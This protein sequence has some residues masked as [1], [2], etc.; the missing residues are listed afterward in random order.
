MKILFLLLF[1]LFT[2][3][4]SGSLV[5]LEYHHVSE[6]TPAVTSISP[7]NFAAHMQYLKDQNFVVLPLDKA[8]R[9]FKSAEKLPDWALAITFDDAYVD[10]YRNAYPLL[11]QLDFPFTIFIATDLVGTNNR[12]YL[13]WD[14]L[15][16]MSAHG[17]LITNH[18]R[19][20]LHMLRFLPSESYEQW[21]SRI[22]NEI[23][24]AQ[25]II[26]SRLGQVAKLFAFPYGE[27]NQDLLSL[28]ADL[29]Y[30]AFGQQSGAI[31]KHSNFLALPRFPLAGAYTGMD[32]FRTKV[33][34]LPLPIHL[35]ETES[36]L[37]A[38]NLRPRLD[39]E[40]MEG[41]WRTA[42]LACFGPGGKMTVEKISTTRFRTAPQEDVPIGRSRYN[43]T[44]PSPRDGRYFWFSQPWIRKN[45]DGSWYPE[46]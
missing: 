13:T 3:E 35:A 14:Q 11:K 34:T 18:S 2:F 30:V 32:S 7:L 15:R 36:L 38:G 46:P 44:M 25:Q 45:D 5:V 12:L 8:I 26:E 43:C 29:D 33:S 27:Y 20:H 6:S 17:A 9:S 40:F 42:D 19:S 23:T 16:E 31:G 24:D 39:L 37:S 41:Q 22:R 4:V 21:Q 28:I 1:S 10:I